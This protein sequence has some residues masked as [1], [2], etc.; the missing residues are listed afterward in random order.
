MG[1]DDPNLVSRFLASPRICAFFFVSVPFSHYR[2]SF[3]H[4]RPSFL[5][6][7]AVFFFFWLLLVSSSPYLL[8]MDTKTSSFS[9]RWLLY[10]HGR[11]RF[12]RLVGFGILSI[13]CNPLAS[14]FAFQSLLAGHGRPSLFYMLWPGFGYPLCLRF[15][16]CFFYGYGNPFLQPLLTVLWAWKTQ[17]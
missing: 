14:S 3:G 17:I 4:G 16:V 7:L 15:L 2:L 13:L 8:S 5:H 12:D 10:G 6:T 1:M 11:P 9:H